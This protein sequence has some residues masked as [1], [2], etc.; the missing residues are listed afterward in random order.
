MAFP[1]ILILQVLITLRVLFFILP[2]AIFIKSV[3]NGAQCS[4][5]CGMHLDMG[6][7]AVATLNSALFKDTPLKHGSL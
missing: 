1:K 3:H 5:I 6:E 7:T 2:L 4:I